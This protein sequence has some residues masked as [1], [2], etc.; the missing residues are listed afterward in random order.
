M[1]SE[2]P[3][4]RAECTSS[5][6]ALR[7]IGVR[8][9]FLFINFFLIITTLYQLKPASKSLFIESLGASSLPYVMIGTAVTMIIFIQQEKDLTKGLSGILWALI[10]TKEF[11]VNH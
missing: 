8:S 9:L 2:N 7:T 3:D 4:L 5:H 10:N 1:N 11:I 6:P